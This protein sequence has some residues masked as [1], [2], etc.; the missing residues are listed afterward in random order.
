MKNLMNIRYLLA[1]FVLLTACAPMSG[2]DV[3]NMTDHLGCMPQEVVDGECKIAQNESNADLFAHDEEILVENVTYGDGM[4]GYLAQPVRSVQLPAVVMIHEWWGLNDNVKDMAKQ[5]A[6]EGFVV[7]AVDLYGEAT[8]ESSR[9]REL[10]SA[11]RANPQGAVENMRSAVAYLRAMPNVK[12]D[13]IASMGWCFGGQQSLQLALSGEDLAGTVIYYG[14]LETDKEKLSV[15][16]WPVLGIFGEEDTGIPVDSVNAFKTALTELNVTNEVI[17]YP[18]VGHAFANPSGA[19]YAPEETKDAWEK[20]VA[21]L[22][23]LQ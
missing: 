23:G 17:I 14:N 6:S 3:D 19:N 13:K 22:K 9:A 15:I 18:D 21:F 16:N 2:H 8:N 12:Q 7:L 1:I 5:L 10:A 4:V 11:V 20:T